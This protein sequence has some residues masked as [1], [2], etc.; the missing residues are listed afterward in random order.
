MAVNTSSLGQFGLMSQFAGAASSAIGAFYSAK[1]MKINLGYQSFMDNLNAGIAEKTAQSA[2]SQGQQQVGM[3]TQRA[4]D[5]KSAQ[6]ASMAANGIDLGEG[7]AAEVQAST[8]LSKQIDA[9]TAT[10][11]AVRAAWGYRMQ[12]TNDQNAALMSQT[13]ANSISPGM[14]GATSLLGSAGK[15]AQSWYS[16]NKTG[17]LNGTPFQLGMN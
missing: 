4:G 5:I 12:V 6:R 2:L 14:A 1:S 7:S 16:M 10:A 9:N 3:I 17:V 15:V 11:N 8:D 13:S